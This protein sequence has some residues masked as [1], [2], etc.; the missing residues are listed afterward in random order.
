MAMRFIRPEALLDYAP[1]DRFPVP[2]AVACREEDVAGET[3]GKDAIA[4]T[5]RKEVR[6]SMFALRTTDRHGYTLEKKTFP[7]YS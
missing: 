1:A 6:T 5:V 2:Q 7:R 4:A 3:A